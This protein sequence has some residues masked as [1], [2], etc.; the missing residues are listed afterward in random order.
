M[1][2]MIG[3]YGDSVVK[4]LRTQYRMNKD[5]MTWAS[6]ALYDGRLLAG[7]EVADHCLA[8]LPGMTRNDF[9]ESVLILLDTAGFLFNEFTTR[10]G[11]SKGNDHHSKIIFAGKNLISSTQP[12]CHCRRLHQFD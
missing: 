11:I 8:D 9:T 6:D 4:M 5:I 12:F 2:R 3:R 7:A 10:D 1:E